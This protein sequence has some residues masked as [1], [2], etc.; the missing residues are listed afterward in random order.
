MA[1]AV[2]GDGSLIVVHGTFS[3]WRL[4]RVDPQSGH[5]TIVSS[6]SI[7]Q[8]PPLADPHAIAVEATGTLVVVSGNNVLRVDPGTGDRTGVTGCPV[9]QACTA[10]K[11][12]GEGPLGCFVALAVEGEGTW[13]VSDACLGALLRVDPVTGDRTVVSYPGQSPS[14]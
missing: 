12:L 4:I 9:P 2:E 8:G 5:R 7:G 13:V 10:D 14:P 11:V 6:E 1:L 3:G